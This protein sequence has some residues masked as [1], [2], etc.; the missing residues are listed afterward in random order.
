MRCPF[1]VFVGVVLFRFRCFC[2]GMPGRPAVETEIYNFDV[3]IFWQDIVN[4]L[5]SVFV[6]C[7]RLPVC[8]VSSA[9][10]LSHREARR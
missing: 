6:R 3:L 5:Y 10:V 9:S 2:D 1:Q 4:V 7:V 8:V